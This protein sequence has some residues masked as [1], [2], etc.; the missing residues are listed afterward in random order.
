VLPRASSALRR[1][2]ASAFLSADAG[3]PATTSALRGRSR[4]REA[5][6]IEEAN[7]SIALVAISNCG[8]PSIL[9]GR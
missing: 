2:S 4:R 9:I 3:A 1:S 6:D 5:I 8:R 7:L